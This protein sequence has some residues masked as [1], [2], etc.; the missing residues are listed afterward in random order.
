MSMGAIDQINRGILTTM[1]NNK[2]ILTKVKCVI[3]L[4][5]KVSKRY[6]GCSNGFGIK[7][8]KHVT[9][10]MG[11][12]RGKSVEEITQEKIKGLIYVTN[13]RIIF[14][15]DKD[16]FD[17]KYSTLTGCTPYS[18]AIKLQF[19]TRTLTLMVSDGCGRKCYYY[20]RQFKDIS[21]GGS[22]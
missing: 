8:S 4:K 20:D 2:I 3:L 12:N 13:K 5:E 19:R 21:D 15:A 1:K 14:M 11:Q 22:A 18:N 17:K 6:E 16:A 9:Y 10:R 7:L